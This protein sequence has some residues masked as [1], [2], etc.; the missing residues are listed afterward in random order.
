MTA[1]DIFAFLSGERRVIDDEMHGDRRL[2][3]LL[4]WDRN[5]I[6]R[7]AECITDVDICDT[8]NRYDG[9]DACFFD[10]YLI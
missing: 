3:N 10:F 6:L 2:W 9:T 8:G 7:A 4:E 5:R 1:C